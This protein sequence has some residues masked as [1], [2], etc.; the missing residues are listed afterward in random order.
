[1]AD[2][3]HARASCDSSSPS[4]KSR[5]VMLTAAKTGM[6][7]VPNI[8]PAL[9]PGPKGNLIVG[10]LPMLSGNG[11]ATIEGWW[12]EFGDIFSYRA[13][14]V[15]VCYLTHPGFIEDVLVSRN[16]NFIKGVG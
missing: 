3:R 2:S 4:G 11:F 6:L 10:N 13:L 15:R 14:S 7:T 16:Q 12:R 9:P 5:I 1:M 8:K